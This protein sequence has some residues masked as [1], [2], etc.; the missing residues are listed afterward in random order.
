MVSLEEEKDILTQNLSEQYSQNII[1]LEEYERILEYINK[2]ET[3]NELNIIKKIILENNIGKKELS[4][5]QNNLLSEA[6]DKHLSLFSWKT[7]NLKSLN[8]YGGKYTSLF[9]TN[10]II[11][12]N[13]PEGRTVLNVN[14]IFGLT[15]IIVP[16]EVKIINKAIP[17]FAGI[18]A[19]N[20]VNEDGNKLPELYILGKAIFGNITIKKISENKF[21]I[22]YAEKV[23]EKIMQ[24]IYDKM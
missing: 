21:E 23:K 9:G 1:N 24:K 18:F 7:S 6:K 15:E 11:V 14:S 13:L 2:V 3:K 4:I 12:D 10:R 16:N 19:P 5:I 22:E 8:G 17:I 20:E